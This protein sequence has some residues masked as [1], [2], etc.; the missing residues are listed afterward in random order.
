MARNLNEIVCS[1]MNSASGLM[2]LPSS[3]NVRQKEAVA[4][5][6]TL[7]SRVTLNE[8]QTEVTGYNVGNSFQDFVCCCLAWLEKFGQKK[9]SFAGKLHET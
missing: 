8:S 9:R 5:L 4:T 2:I 1:F 6:C 7:C 3:L